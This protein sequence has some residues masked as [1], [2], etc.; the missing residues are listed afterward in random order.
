MPVE[1]KGGVTGTT[2]PTPPRHKETQTPDSGTWN[3]YQV[4]SEA[5]TQKKLARQPS[6]PDSGIGTP[7][8]GRSISPAPSNA[9]DSA[10]SE[11]FPSLDRVDSLPQSSKPGTAE[12]LVENCHI[13]KVLGSGANGE[14]HLLKDSSKTSGTS[15]FVLKTA[16]KGRELEREREIFE[17]LGSHPNIVKCHGPV[18]V[19]GTSG[20]LLER[21]N[22]PT[23]SLITFKLAALFEENKLSSQEYFNVLAY[24]EEQKFQAAA[25]LEQ[26][27]TVHGD[28]GPH[29]FMFDLDS[30][31][32]KLIDFGRSTPV[33]KAMICGNLDFTPPEAI[34][35]FFGTKLPTAASPTMD[36]YA[37]GQ[38]LYKTMASLDK[39]MTGEPYLHNANVNELAS[40]QVSVR[41]QRLHEALNDYATPNDDGSY[42]QA[43][44][45]PAKT[46]VQNDEL[47]A[48][49]KRLKHVA[50]FEQLYQAVEEA[51]QSRTQLTDLVNGL[52]HPVSPHRTT[53]QEA[54]KHPWLTS[55][56]IDREQALQTLRNLPESV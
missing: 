17:R 44:T 35:A 13:G 55:R 56:S 24:L 1:G 39:D 51:K 42:K 21:I 38:M 27:K 18:T 15:G 10:S 28:I 49:S 20:L 50:N 46:E 4:T 43:L 40:S 30:G 36:C 31:L 54:L 16:R 33:G 9:P 48:E 12:Q 52:L 37:L 34:G 45:P 23:L 11:V 47:L 6:T 19:D 5:N 2:T 29:N 25:H 26:H 22:G 8:S 14:I 53:A 7:L 41:A 3:T 32:V